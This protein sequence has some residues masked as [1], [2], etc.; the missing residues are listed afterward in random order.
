[1]T[2]YLTDATSPADI[3]EAKDSG[4]VAYKLYPAG[5]TTNSS[6]GVTNFQKVIPTLKAMADVSANKHAFPT[7]VCFMFSLARMN[8]LGL[9]LH[10]LKPTHSA[11]DLINYPGAVIILAYHP[12][13][14]AVPQSAALH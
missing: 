10:Q 7:L 11:Q 6:S 3:Y 12:V 5:A 2:C 14:T 4:V 9:V 13:V 1:M 8:A